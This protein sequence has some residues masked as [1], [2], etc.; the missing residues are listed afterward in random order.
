M[1]LL[2][3]FEHNLKKN[4]RTCL[5]VEVQS[6]DSATMTVNV[7]PLIQGIRAAEGGREIK[8]ETGE[9]IL[10]ED[11]QL[12]SIL[13]L[14]ICLLWQ[15]SIG[16]TIPIIAGM[17]GM[18]IVCDRDIRLW[19]SSRVLS[20]QASLRKSNINDSFFLPFLPQAIE[21]Y[22]NEAVEIRNGET[23]LSVGNGGVNITGNLIVNGI[24]FL[25]HSHLYNDNGTP[26]QTGE[27]E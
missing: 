18:A 8:T 24:D 22:S 5:P 27:P 9:K 15:G 3:F 21:N 6:F 16:I 19:K 14:P 7:K 12:P 23:K 13:D 20:R 17:Q 2:K 11:Y 25:T 10:V 26:T 4:L 1:K